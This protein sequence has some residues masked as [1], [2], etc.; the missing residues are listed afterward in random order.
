MFESEYIKS[1]NTFAYL[2]ENKEHYW[3]KSGWE[4]DDT[5]KF[6]ANNI[7]VCNIPVDL[8]K[9]YIDNSE[10]IENED[11]KESYKNYYNKGLYFNKSNGNEDKRIVYKVLRNNDEVIVFS[12]V[13]DGKLVSL[14]NSCNSI[15]FAGEDKYS[16]LDNYLKEIYKQNI[17]AFGFSCVATV[18]LV[19]GFI[20]FKKKYSKD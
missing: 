15:I 16:R 7:S 14:S 4:T 8:K 18:V 13:K 5:A 11:I 19:V 1:T 10:T 9:F 17:F 20:I 2:E 6:Y 3:G 12:K